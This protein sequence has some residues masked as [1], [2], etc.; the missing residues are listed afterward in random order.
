MEQ[1]QK[2]RKGEVGLHVNPGSN[3]YTKRKR[4]KKKKTTYASKEFH[5]SEIV[6]LP[7]S[8]YFLRKKRK[9][10]KKRISRAPTSP[11]LGHRGDWVER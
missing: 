3:S 6:K 2:S 4:K 11:S 9:G 10:K 5:T 1:E 7:T 8:A